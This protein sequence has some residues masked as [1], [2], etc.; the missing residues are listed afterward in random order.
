MKELKVRLTFLEN[1]LGS[2][3]N[4]KDLY[5]E[6]LGKKSP[7]APSLEEE[8]EALGYNAVAEKGATVFPKDDDGTPIFWAYQIEGFFKGTCGFLRNVEG[9]LSSKVKA[10]KKTIDGRIFVMGE[11]SPTNR[12]GR[13]IRIENALRIEKNQRPLRA[14][15]PQGERI[16]LACSEEIPAGASCTFTIKMLN[17]DDEALV[18]EWLDFGELNGIGQWRNAG[19]GRFT[20]EEVA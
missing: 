1:I 9:T 3:P 4:N 18:R 17:D 11:K 10:Y 13:K 14:S 20:W 7:D 12:T 8:I 5:T 16:S 6:F 2:S 15:T 19:Y